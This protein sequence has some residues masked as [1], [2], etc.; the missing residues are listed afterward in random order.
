M[1]N[2]NEYLLSYKGYNFVK[3]KLVNIEQLEK[4]EDFEIRD[5]D[6]FIVTY[7]KS[8]ECT[9]WLYQILRLIFYEGHWNRTGDIKTVVKTP[10][11][12][13]MFYN[14][15]IIK[16]PSPRIFTSHLPYYL[17]PQY[18]RKKK[19]K[20]LR[21]TVLK[22]CSFLEKERSEGDVDSVERQA[23]FQYMKTD[24]QTDYVIIFK[25]DIGLRHKEGSCL[26]KGERASLGVKRV[27]ELALSLPKE[28]LRKAGPD[29]HLGI[30][31]ELI[32]L[33]GMKVNQP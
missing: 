22:I 11:F 18:L 23:T 12:E 1:D 7:P 9:I 13:Y 31:V 15:D 6:V 5:D 25:T 17:V 14:L 19:A 21:S 30:I 16:M 10:C 26:R 4:L 27:G 20:D 2:T 8:G 29:P 24:P 28:A 32:L 3:K 33:A